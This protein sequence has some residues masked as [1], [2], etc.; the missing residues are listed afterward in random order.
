VLA[1][2]RAGQVVVKPIRMVASSKILALMGRVT[3]NTIDPGQM[4]FG[5]FRAAGD[6]P[7]PT[8]RQ[9]FRK[10]SS[11]LIHIRT[12]ERTAFLDEAPYRMRPGMRMG[13]IPFGSANGAAVAGPFF[14]GNRSMFP[15][16]TSTRPL[17]AGG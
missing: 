3:L 16:I 17:G 7:W 12:I 8:D 15:L 13:V 11:R 2:G 1:L 5:P 10:L 14:L 9:P 4:F 6:V